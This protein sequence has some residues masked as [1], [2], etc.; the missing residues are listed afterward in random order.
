VHATALTFQ[1][2][3]FSLERQS[4]AKSRDLA[5]LARDHV[6]SAPQHVQYMVQQVLL[7]HGVWWWCDVSAA[8][9]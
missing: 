7:C 1:E 3:K 4:A 5:L 2:K 8:L 6:T 9:F